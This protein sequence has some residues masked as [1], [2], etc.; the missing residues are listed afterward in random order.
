MKGQRSLH[1]IV[2]AFICAFVL[3]HPVNAIKETG[4]TTLVGSALSNGGRSTD[5]DGKCPPCFN[6]MLPIFECKHFSDCNPNTGRCE[7]LEGFAGDDCSIPV[8]GGLSDDNSRRPQRSNET[9]TCDCKPGWGGINCNVCEEDFVCDAFMPDKDWKG[10]CYKNGMIVNK[11]Y[12]GC[13]VTN[14]KIL[15]ILKG[16]I[17]QVTFF[18]DRKKK[19]CN[20]QFWIDEL[21]SF[22]CGLDNCS[23]SYDLQSN[24]SHYQ[25]EDVKCRCIPDAMLC[26][27]HGSI[28]ISEFLSETIKG[29]GD[30]S[31]D[32]QTKDC[33]FTEPSMNELIETIFG[34]PYITLR[35]ESGECLHYS[36]IPG[37]EPPSKD[38]V[39]S[40]RAKIILSLTSVSLLG[41]ITFVSF[42]ISKS[43][44][45]KN[46]TIHLV[47]DGSNDESFLKSDKVATLSFENI[48]YGINNSKGYEEI[49]NG[50]SGAVKP[51]EIMAL[52]GGSG[53]GKTTLLDILAMKRKT[54]QV[55]GSIRVNGSDIS[56]KDYSKLI[57]FVDQDD[58]LLPT[59]TVYE[60][61][62]NSA[63]L[64]LPRALSFA[65]KQSR[66]YQVLEELRIFHIKDRVIGND[67]ERGISGGEK[68]R[69]SI[70]CELVTSPLVL[71]LDEPTSGLDANNANNVVECL[72]RLAKTYNR[73]LV[74]SIHQP[75]SN[76][77]HL[78]DKLILLSSG[79]MVYSGEAIRVSEFLR[80]NG[81][82][83]PSDYN[84]ADY[85]IDITFESE[86]RKKKPDVSSSNEDVEI[87]AGLFSPSS[88]NNGLHAA[89]D[90]RNASVGSFNQREWEHLAGHRDEI[91][92]LLAESVDPQGETLGSMNTKLLNIRFKEGPYYAELKQEIDT[93][94]A[95][96]QETS[97]ELP[98]TL[99]A[100]SFFQQL[101]ILCS[102]S[103]KNI[104]RN[105][106]LLLANYLLT[107]VLGLFLGT[108]YYDV[109]NDISGFQNRMG[110]FFFILT[111]FGFV[112]FTGLSSFAMERIIFIKE[113]SNNY[114]SPA[115]YFISKVL[116]D[117]LPLRVVPPVLLALV[118]YPLVGLNMKGQ[119][120][121]I[122]IGV[123][124]MFNLGISL[125]ILAIGI[126]FEDLNNSI[127]F[128]VLILLGSLLFSG[129]FINTKD[130]TNMAFKYLKNLS[131]FYY[132]YESLL[133]NEVKNLTLRETKYGLKIEVP[134][135]T[136]LSTFGFVV[137]NMILDVKILC[138]F[139]V[140]FLLIGYLALKLIV[141]EQ[142]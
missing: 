79:E 87:S 35:C 21:E 78:F 26:G 103:F 100:A 130:I 65:A 5:D 15:Q 6:C 70:A 45:F 120:F 90:D 38:V 37:Y 104:Y 31:C 75:R 27:A 139:N 101:S 105:P 67:F 64:R 44:L 128:S 69:V 10:T 123:L 115:A 99:K 142:K 23:F 11:L 84:I 51:G 102:R 140:V 126:I 83:C 141:V 138:L 52:L 109:S 77:F 28:D 113:R 80:N 106:K 118:V 33:R 42:Y 13:N 127:I 81:Y 136:I 124:V 107:I 137:Q 71:F 89:L 66:V 8:C 50:I 17:P 43:P 131:L 41:L 92:N 96:H 121:L 94:D 19:A 62:L 98:S 111:Y 29:P 86:G 122:F 56:R 47:E 46:G 135:A 4:R 7:C 59:L 25:C 85:L 82:Q 119:A 132:A 76:I 68:R 74:L 116:S 36:E 53:A 3:C 95:N 61:V 63:L 16:Q 91:R 22:Y 34:D 134:G 114:Y 24:S 110:L 48:A 108:L 14:E 129:L 2:I 9:N 73:T 60:T 30:F 58:Y 39:M 57:G 112:T 18:C 117:V 72:V 20:F 97:I 54:G 93:I 1:I 49:L 133:I 125:E 32:L 88:K 40:W 12:Q 55:K